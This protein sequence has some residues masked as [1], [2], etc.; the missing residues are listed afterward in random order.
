M[1]WCMLHKLSSQFL[2]FTLWFKLFATLCL[3]RVYAQSLSSQF[4]SFTLWFKLFATFYL[5]RHPTVDVLMNC[6]TYFD[7][8]MVASMAVAVFAGE[9]LTEHCGT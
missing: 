8:C 2:S 1:C 6:T 5:Q 3:Q 4:L 9:T 7:V